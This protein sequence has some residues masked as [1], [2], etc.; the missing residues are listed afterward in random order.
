VELSSL[1]GQATGR[2]LRRTQDLVLS[3]VALLL[4]GPVA[5]WRAARPVR[6]SDPFDLVHGRGG[7]SFRRRRG[8]R[9]F[10]RLAETLGHVLRGQLALVGP[11][12]V[13]PEE[14][15]RS[16][17]FRLL[18][19]LA[20]PGATGPWRLE[21][22]SDLGGEDAGSAPAEEASR[23]LAYLQNQTIVEDLKVILRTVARTKAAPRSPSRSNP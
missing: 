23:S 1:A 6:E 13:T 11:R 14:A 16:E 20:R 3:S 2:I 21:E 18:F 15:A 7:Q 22:P 17:S 19:D 4:M 9:G 12:P 10:T 8:T 5:W